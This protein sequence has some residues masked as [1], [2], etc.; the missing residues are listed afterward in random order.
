VITDVRAAL[1]LTRRPEFRKMEAMRDERS[2]TTLPN[3][4]RPAW[5]TA[6]ALEALSRAARDDARIR[7]TGDLL[8]ALVAEARRN[9]KVGV[10][11]CGDEVT[12]SVERP[13]AEGKGCPRWVGETTI[14]QL[15]T[16]LERYGGLIGLARYALKE[17]R[18]E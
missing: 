6:E 4:G 13:H 7:I 3:E 2:R 1:D 8:S 17:A 12:I 16:Y 9:E 11:V 10:H 18:I 14:E 5:R 15:C